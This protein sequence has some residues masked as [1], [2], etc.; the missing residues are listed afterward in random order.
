M[1]NLLFSYNGPTY[2]KM[3]SADYS[4]SLGDSG[5]PVISSGN[6]YIVGI[7]KGTF[8]GYSWFSPVSGIKTDLRDTPIKS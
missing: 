4:S 1:F 5:S 6:Y 8:N 7:H 2:Y 3:T